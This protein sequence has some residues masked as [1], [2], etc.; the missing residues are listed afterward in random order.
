MRLSKTASPSDSDRE[1]ENFPDRPSLP[2]L[3]LF[4]C[5][6]WLGS[7]AAGQFPYE[8][9]A[10][11]AGGGTLLSLCCI[12]A[13]VACLK[14]SK[15]VFPFVLGS[16]LC[17]GFLVASLALFGLHESR[18][19]WH[20]LSGSQMAFRVT[21]DVSAGDFGYSTYAEAWVA[22]DAWHSMP[23]H[24][25][26]VK[27]FLE[28]SGLSYGDEF[29]AKASFSL[30]RESA[31]TSYDRK[32]VALGCTP[33][34]IEFMEPSRMGLLSVARAS[35]S[36]FI[37]S[38]T[39]DYSLD[40]SSSAV[41][42]ALVIGERQQLFEEAVYQDVKTCGLAHM[43]AVSGAHLVIVLGM[44]NSVLRALNVSRRASVAVQLLFLCTYLVL[45]GFPVSCL[46][47]SAMAAIG[48]VS[49]TVRRR[50]YALSSLGAA[51]V[52]LIAVDPS[53]AC[54]LSFALSAFSTL[55]IVLFTPLLTAWLPS[56]GD[57]FRNWITEPLAM[58]LA[59]LLFTFPLSIVA[60]SQF[61]VVSPLANILT[62][63]LVSAS[64]I[65]GMLG[66]VAM[67]VPYLG[68]ALSLIAYAFCL[69]FVKVSAALAAMPFASIPVSLPFLFMAAFSMLMAA[70]LW[71]FWPAKA[72]IRTVG[73]LGV[74]CLLCLSVG[75]VR[76]TATTSVA[77]LD[78]GQGDAILFRS[79]GATLLVD[80][81]NQTQKLLSAL[82]EQG[83]RHLDG[84]VV[85]H[86]DDDHC[87]SLP[88]L[89][90]VVSCDR[91]FVANGIKGLGTD[92]TKAVVDEASSL[93]GTSNVEEVSA[94]DTL[95]VGALSLRCISPNGLK[96]EGGNQ[97]SVVLLMLS[98][99]DGD[100][101]PEWSGLFGGDAESG[102][103]EGLED[104][105]A[106]GAVDIL[107]VSHHGAKAAMTQG[108]AEDLRP[109]LALVSVGKNNRYGHPASQTLRYLQE[110]GTQV[111]RTDEQGTVVCNLESAELKVYCMR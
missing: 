72:P 4:G 50:S 18:V 92:K 11:L 106:V 102:V 68:S 31:V 82:A 70:L 89:R 74:A 69:V 30:P 59:A 55:G 15:G 51:M 25:I 39:K 60:F 75:V 73:A 17:L 111:L 26:K 42:K 38:L 12:A 94:G 1:L 65:F 88:A 3:L 63:P 67:Q 10:W 64:C 91:V 21:E 28:D 85:T 99:L 14:K 61:P 95:R 79:K 107:K 108:L 7:Y 71:F 9:N 45:V 2:P 22:G 49:F 47:A 80:T 44:V 27:L 86:P 81:G 101:N 100:G 24:S 54:S 53:A 32:H 104:S 29:V 19:A 78:V 52:L 98:D 20:N 46:R 109:Q 8:W 35:F 90:G 36:G 97:D 43:V 40:A 110:Q 66:F 16:A 84:I 58:T 56:V 37:D 62:V 105:G 34:D 96:D 48:L 93:V 23:G 76:N 41:L 77:M 13:T 33:S 103:L 83:V 5:F 57:R 87:G 6:F